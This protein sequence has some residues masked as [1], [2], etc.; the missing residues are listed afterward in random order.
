M[1]SEPAAAAGGS[2]P[3]SAS[4]V[5]AGSANPADEGRIET[6]I[7]LQTFRSV[8]L[9]IPRHILLLLLRIKSD[10]HVLSALRSVFLS[11]IVTWAREDTITINLGF[12]RVD[13]KIAE[14]ELIDRTF[15]AW[16]RSTKGALSL[17]ARPPFTQSTA[18]GDG[19]S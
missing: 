5:P 11:E 9:P 10:P 15:F 6:R 13:R 16:D 1:C 12:Q 19:L 2:S 14:H 4:K 3:A 17:Q 18:A 7:D 8:F